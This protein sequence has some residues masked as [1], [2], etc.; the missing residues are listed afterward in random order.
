MAKESLPEKSDK[1]IGAVLNTYGSAPQE[2]KDFYNK[3]M[4]LRGKVLT[5][6]FSLN[7]GEKEKF[8]GKLKQKEYESFAS[9]E[10]P[11]KY[12]SYHKS[13][14]SSVGPLT[15]PILDFE[16]EHSLLKFYEELYKEM[17]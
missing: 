5:K 8:L 6:I 13:I 4:D 16:G 12:L 9:V 17:S 1:T 3:F 14:A 15:A 2:W 7:Q 10:D 11:S